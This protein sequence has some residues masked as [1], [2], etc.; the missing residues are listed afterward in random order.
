MSV[1]DEKAGIGGVLDIIPVSCPTMPDMAEVLA[2]VRQGARGGDL[3]GEE[4]EAQFEDA[5][6]AYLHCQHAVA[7]SSSTFGLILSLAA[8]DIPPGPEVIVPS[9]AFGATIQAIYWNGLTPVFVDCLPE[10]MTIDP[11]EVVAAISPTTAAIVPVAIFGLP[12]DMGALEDISRKYDLPV[13]FDSSQGLGSLY[14]GKPIGG[15]GRCEVFSLNSE[16]VVTAAEG[17]V[18]VTNDSDLSEKLRAMR[19]WGQGKEGQDAVSMGVSSR[20]GMFNAAVGLL[21]LRESERLVASRLRLIDRYRT[22]LDRVPGCSFQQQVADRKSNGTYFAV[23][24]DQQVGKNRDQIHEGLKEKGIESRRMFFPPA[25]AHQ[26]FRGRPA[27]VVGDLRN[28]WAASSS[29]LA[30]PLYSHMTDETVDR[31][32]EAIQCLAGPDP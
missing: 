15:Y 29:G 30:L 28:T 18:V 5:L 2:L 7:V 14:C 13:I 31:V 6:R 11:D 32:C 3:S 8:M 27:R 1:V 12:P 21:S 23:F 20:I 22:R 25:H 9:F 17:G 4:T 26:A 10:T 24:I 16:M 19:Q